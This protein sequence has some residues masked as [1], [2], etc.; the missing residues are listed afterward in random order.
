MKES[1]LQSAIDSLPHSIKPQR[2]L[3]PGIDK[4]LENAGRGDGSHYQA[5]QWRM[6]AMAAAIMLALTGGIFIGRG[7]D[8]EP[9]NAAPQI[10]MEN[11]MLGTVAATEREYQAAF[12]EL[13]PLDYSGLLLGGEEPDALRESWEDLLH[14]E[15]SLLAAL[16]EFPKDIFLNEK[17]LDLRSQQLQ[18]VKQLAMLEQNN[19]RRT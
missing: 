11:A 14:T 19:W 4:R 6:P 16:R 12:S 5:P 8:T 1:E 17:L 2:D 9:L 7:I 18:F 10:A 3:W 15:S 13:V